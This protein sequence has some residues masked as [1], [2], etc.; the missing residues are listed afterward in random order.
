MTPERATSSLVILLWALEV[1]CIASFVYMTVTPYVPLPLQIV[2]AV[3]Q[4]VII[5]FVPFTLRRIARSPSLR[6]WRTVSIWL[7]V[8]AVVAIC[9]IIPVTC[10]GYLVRT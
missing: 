9:A 3:L 7:L 4:G 1:A 6:G 8:T 5:G 2:P 10:V